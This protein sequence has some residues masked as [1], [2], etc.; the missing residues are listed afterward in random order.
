MQ[1]HTPTAGHVHGAITRVLECSPTS[2]R[3]AEWPRGRCPDLNPGRTRPSVELVRGVTD[4]RVGHASPPGCGV[5]PA[6]CGGTWGKERGTVDRA[7]GSYTERN[8]RSTA[9][10]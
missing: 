2:G 8:K 7:E 3:A 4:G 1:E 6:A 10:K 5:V 9:A